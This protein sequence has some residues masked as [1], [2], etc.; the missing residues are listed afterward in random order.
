MTTRTLFGAGAIGETVRQVQEVLITQGC[1]FAKADG[2]FGDGTAAAIKQF[3]TKTSLA[4]TGVMDNATWQSLMNRPVPSAGDRSLQL[5][6]AFEGHGFELAV[7]NFDGALITWGVIGFTMT[8]GEIQSIVL[9]VNKTHPELVK[10][11]F[12]VHA[13]ELLQ[14]M[15]ATRD[16]QKQWANEHTVT[17]R[18]LAEPWRSMFAMFGSFPGVQQE[19]L[20][21]VKEG[22]LDPAAATAKRLGLTSELGLALCFDAHVQNGGIKPASL[23]SLL[24]KSKAGLAELELRELIA[25]AVADTARAA[26]REDVRTRKLTIATGQGKV[27]GHVFVLDNWGLSGKFQAGELSKTATEDSSAA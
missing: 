25:N 17:S 24:Q 7:G 15:N 13:D 18:S 8:S 10:Q 22:Y 3:Q 12:G 20:K 14:L 27:H 23:K 5:T 4:V 6:A 21:H 2:V 1:G 26:W 19:Q 11:A 9:A 16:F